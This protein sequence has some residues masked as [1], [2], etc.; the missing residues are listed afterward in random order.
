MNPLF[1]IIPL[2]LFHFCFNTELLAQ[3]YGN[4]W[5]FGDSLMLN[6]NSCVPV[7]SS[8]SNEGFEGCSTISD[9][10]GNLLFYTNSVKVWNKNHN[11]MQNGILMN[12]VGTISQVLIIP[13]PLSIKD[14]Y[15]FTVQV[16]ASPFSPKFQYHEIDM[17]LN[18]GLG[19]VTNKNIIIDTTAITEQIAATWHSNGV[20]IWVMVHEYGTSNF[21]AYLVTSTGISFSPII[22]SIGSIHSSCFSNIN[23]R[24]NIKFSPDGT[25]LAFN[26]NGW[27]ANIASNLL[28]TF[29]FDNSTGIVSNQIKL[30]FLRGEFGLSF[31][32]DNSKLYCTTWNA[33]GNTIDSNYLYQFDLS[34]GDSNTIVNSRQVIHSTTLSEVFGSIKIGPDGKIYVARAFDNYIG[35]INNPNQAGASC[36]YNHSGIDLNE[37]ECQHGLN[38]YIEYT[39][40]CNPVSILKEIRETNLIKILPNPYSNHFSIEGLNNP[41][42]LNIYNAMGQLLYQENNIFEIS[43]RVVADCF[44]N[45][46]L[47]IRIKSENEFFNYK[48][49]KK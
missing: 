10:L 17:N 25:K 29:D 1:K 28:E 22:S 14:Y 15:V 26:A 44:S 30:P 35:V 12:T 18:S 42:D 34:S 21:K 8:S 31:S 23:A 36:N 45:G 11:L 9:S 49:L 38:N 16:Q 27:G 3:K 7:V 48:L 43:K 47:F 33:S 6:F 2:I 39:S 40:Y 37:K 20:D 32:P 24:G 4:N 5:C 46:L 13:K 19:A 41:Y